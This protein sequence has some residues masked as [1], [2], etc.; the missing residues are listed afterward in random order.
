M[1]YKCGDSPPLVAAWPPEGTPLEDAFGANEGQ[2]ALIPPR[3]QALFG[4]NRNHGNESTY[5]NYLVSDFQPAGNY[6]LCG[7]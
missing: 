7:I 6:L 2:M 3:R 1:H 4:G 5:T